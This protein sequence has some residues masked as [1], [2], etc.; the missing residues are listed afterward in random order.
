MHECTVSSAFLNHF[1]YKSHKQFSKYIY[2]M[3]AIMRATQ[4]PASLF[5]NT[6]SNPLTAKII[7]N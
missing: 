2:E 7:K 4:I 6:V 5:K 1:I 3:T